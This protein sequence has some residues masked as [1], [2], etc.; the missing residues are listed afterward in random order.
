MLSYYYSLQVS[1]GSSRVIENIDIAPKGDWNELGS[2][3]NIS[4]SDYSN[5][6]SFYPASIA[7]L[8]EIKKKPVKIINRLF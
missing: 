1:Y 4:E 7:L 6:E 3:Q 8:S 2:G 5:I